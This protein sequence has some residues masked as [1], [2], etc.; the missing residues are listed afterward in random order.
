M[1]RMCKIYG[2]VEENLKFSPACECQIVVC[3]DTFQGNTMEHT[4]ERGT[5]GVAFSVRQFLTQ[6]LLANG[7]PQQAKPMNS[8]WKQ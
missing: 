3:G 6:V 1:V 7:Q 4:G 2:S 5:N 8:P